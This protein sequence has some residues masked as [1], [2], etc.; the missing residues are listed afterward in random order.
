MIRVRDSGIG[1]APEAVPRMFELFA[2]GDRSL[3]RS[4]GGL[5][6]GLTL[7]R[8]LAESH[9]GSLSATSE[10]QGKGT[11]FVL[12]LPAGVTPTAATFARG[13]EIPGAPGKASRVLLV[14]DHADTV[15]SISGLLRLLGYQVETARDGPSAIEA[16]ACSG[17]TWCC[18]TS[19]CPRWMDTRS[20]RASAPR[21]PARKPASSR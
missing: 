21:S 15:R 20:P 1:M 8:S 16:R 10:G 19:G 13:V 12:R 4:E 3:A 18:S 7:A 14:E 2:Q 17:P 5:G 6:L 9:G 11:E